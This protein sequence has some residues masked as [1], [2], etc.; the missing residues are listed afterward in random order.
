MSRNWP[1]QCT[2]L[3]FPYMSPEDM[4]YRLR[5]DTQSLVSARADQIVA[6][7][8]WTGGLTPSYPPAGHGR[9]TLRF[10]IRY[11]VVLLVISEAPQWRE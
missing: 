6:Y 8:I 10:C 11:V 1:L 7:Y 3:C 2:R 9:F 5:F 4:T